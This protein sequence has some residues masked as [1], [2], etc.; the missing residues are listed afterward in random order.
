MYYV[1]ERER[2]REREREKEWRGHSLN[3]FPKK[4]NVRATQRSLSH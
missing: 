4:K 3:H 2:E 1:S